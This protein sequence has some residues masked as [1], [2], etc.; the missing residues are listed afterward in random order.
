M[1]RRVMVPSLAAAMVLSTVA[2]PAA[3]Q[4]DGSFTLTVLHSN[5][6]E[7]ALLPDSYD[8]TGDEDLVDLACPGGAPAPGFADV[9]PANTHYAAIACGVERDVIFGVTASTYQP[10]GTLTR[11]QTASLL[12]RALVDAGVELPALA[13]APTFPDIGPPHGDNVRR[14]AAAEI[15]AGRTDGTFC[16]GDAV[17]R[18]QLASL[19]VRSLAYYRGSDVEPEGENPFDDVTSGPHVDNIVAASELGL[20]R[21]KGDGRFAPRDATQRDQAA[22]LVMR[23]SGRI[24]GEDGQGGTARFVDF[25]KSLQDAAM[26]EDAGVLTIS[27]GD[28]FLAGPEYTAS[29]ESYRDGGDFYDALVFQEAGYDAMII[30]NHEFDFGPEGLAEFIGAFGEDGPP[31]LSANL[32]FSNEPVL[33]DL[34]DDGRIASSAVFEVEGREVGVIGATT[35]S[36]ATVSSPGDVII[37]DVLPAVEAEVA[38]LEGE[39]VDLIILSS[40]LQDLDNERDLIAEL[41]GVDAVIGGGGAEDIRDAYPFLIEDADG[42]DVPLVTTPGSYRDVGQLVLEFDADGDLVAVGDDSGLL[43]VPAFGPKDAATLANVEIP[44]AEALAGLAEQVIATTEVALDARTSTVRVRE[45]TL[46]NLMSDGLLAAARRLADDFGVDEADVALQNGGGIRSDSLFPAGPISVLDTFNF[47]PFGNIVSVDEVS[48]AELRALIEHGIGA[49]PSVSGRFGQWAGVEFNY[50]VSLPEGSRITNAVVTRADGTEVNLVVA[51]VTNAAAGDFTIAGL[52]FTLGGGDG[53][54]FDG[55]FTQ[56][57]AYTDQRALRDY[58]EGDLGGT[59]TAA[60]YPELDPGECT[61]FG[62]VGNGCDVTPL[63]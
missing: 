7:S 48:A 37:N 23:L 4:E 36:L 9:P 28:N 62:P 60:Q 49:L 58:L 35:E 19:I 54:P 31:F 46:G 59:V 3:G 33:D 43:A 22:S 42:N 27:S 2:L 63:P 51:G 39:G 8:F 55:D 41:S 44:V 50:D 18:D 25:V 45:A 26:G 16:T 53:Y 13:G 52:N 6:G 32:D 34:V 29:V 20:V 11:G 10:F 21:G 14:L 61:R 40:H 17:T 24:V 30:G 47:A 15:I 1:M 5:D 56:L 38:A 57:G 12:A